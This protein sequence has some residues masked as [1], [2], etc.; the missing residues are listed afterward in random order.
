MSIERIGVSKDASDGILNTK[1]RGEIVLLPVL[2]HRRNNVVL[3][4]INETMHT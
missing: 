3:C 4:G 2:N 1:D